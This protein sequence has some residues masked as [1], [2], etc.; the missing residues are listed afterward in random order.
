MKIKPFISLVGLI[1]LT[2]LFSP[3]NSMAQKQFT[4]EDLNFGG[5]NFY[6]MRPEARY[7]TW[8]GSKPVRQE[9][10]SCSL[11]DPANGKET[12]LF[13]LDEIN[14]WAGLTAS[15]DK[16]RHLYNVEFPYADRPIALVQNG[17]E[18]IFVNFKTHKTEKKQERKQNTQARDWNQSSAATAYVLDHQLY[19]TDPNGTDH[20]LTRMV[21][22]ILSMD[23]A[24]TGMSLVST[25]DSSGVRK[26]TVLPSIAWTKAWLMTIHLLTFQSLIGNQ[27]RANHVLQRLILS[28]ILW[29]ERPHTRS[30]WVSMTCQLARQSTS[31]QVILP[32]VTSRI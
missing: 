21:H 20:Q 32:T 15:E 29:R 3:T 2:G 9:L 11:I 13:T 10:N 14:E 24:S 7:L 4:L 22:V 12:K 16:I 8:W 26:A 27:P 30:L 28:N 31:K 6:S 23:K 25:E 1:A 5:K 18:N 17:H 19:V